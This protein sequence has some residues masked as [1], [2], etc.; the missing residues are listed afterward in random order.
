MNTLEY[1][2]E[3]IEGLSSDYDRDSDWI[4]GQLD[5]YRLAAKRTKQ[6]NITSFLNVHH[7][8]LSSAAPSSYVRGKLQACEAL[9][10]AMNKG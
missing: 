2:N 8:S 5:F 1:I 4:K 3:R 6:M 9:I 7:R 10:N